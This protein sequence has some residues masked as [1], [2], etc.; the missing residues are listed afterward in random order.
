M[1]QDLVS[2][3]ENTARELINNIHTAIPGEI[4]EFDARHSLARVK[5][6][7]KV[8]TFSGEKLDY[9]L[10]T[11]VPVVFPFSESANI[12]IT[13]PV[14]K[15]DS[16][17]VVISESELDE[18]RNKAISEMPLKFDLSSAICIP[19]LMKKLN[20]ERAIKEKAV[21]INSK[22]SEIIVSPNAVSITAGGG[23]IRVQDSGITIKGNLK[24]DGNIKAIG[25]IG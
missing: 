20:S 6:I 13:F 8:V 17:L 15:G 14:R 21:V 2:E 12:G 18:W 16:C 25:T 24:V 7:G 5:P 19:G 10:L 9:P 1:I 3:I 23:Q 11:E 22:S 4:Q